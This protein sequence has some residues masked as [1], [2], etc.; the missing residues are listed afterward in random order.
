MANKKEWTDEEVQAEIRE[1]VRIVAEDREKETYAG[2]HSKYGPKEGDADPGKVP[3]P[4]KE[5]TEDG[6]KPKRKSMWWG[7]TDES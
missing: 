5:K 3:P 2:L 7:E 6:E 1:A 4:P